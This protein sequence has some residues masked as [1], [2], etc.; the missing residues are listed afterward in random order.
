GYETAADGGDEW[1]PI[2]RYYATL[3]SQQMCPEEMYAGIDIDNAIDMYLF[4]NLIQGIDHVG[5]IDSH[6]IKNMFLSFHNMDGKE[7]VLYTP[8]DMDVTWGQE[9]TGDMETNM[10]EPYGIKSSQNVVMGL[11]NLPA[12]ILDGDDRIWSLILEKYK[13]F[14]QGRWSE[15]SLNRML[16]VLEDDIYMSGAYVRDRERWPEGSYQDADRKLADFRRYIA[17]RLDEMDAYYARVEDAVADGRADNM[18]ILR[19]L[20]YKDFLKSDFILISSGDVLNEGDDYGEFLEYVGI[21]VE[22]LRDGTNMVAIDGGEKR[23]EYYLTDNFMD[24]IDTCIGHIG[25]EENIETGQKLLYVDGILWCEMDKKSSFNL[26]FRNGE[27][28]SEFDFTREY[29]MWS[30]AVEQGE[31]DTWRKE[32]E[33]NGYDL[34]IEILNHDIIEEERFKASLEGLGVDTDAVSRHTDFIALRNMGE[35][36]TILD[37]SH[38]SGT[39]CDTALGEFSI[40]YNDAGGYGV[41]INTNECM[42]VSSGENDNVDIRVAVMES[43][44]YRVIWCPTFMY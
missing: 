23:I 35:T 16:D 3:H 8:W 17:E 30:R 38:E 13:R 44:P 6:S 34:L 41:Y 14:R 40:F 39:R 19:S 33:K 20:Q 1:E 29:V 12:I 32:L 42:I 21:D 2:K 27:A 4:I 43:V 11:G 15:E 18:Y 28:V 5:A 22:R 37:N 36:V 26:V 24:G 10:I 31:I 9:W 25:I 7:T